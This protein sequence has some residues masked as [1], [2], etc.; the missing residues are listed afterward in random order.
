M[1]T[2]LLYRCRPHS[3]A[4]FRAAALQ[5]YADAEALF[6]Q[7]HRTGSVYLFGYAAEMIVKAAWFA[8]FGFHADQTITKAD[9]LTAVKLAPAM[10]V[11]PPLSNAHDIRG[12]GQS[13]FQL[14][15][16]LPGAEYLDASIG[17]GLLTH[18]AQV[19]AVWR[20]TLRYHKNTAYPHEVRGIRTAVEW[21]VTHSSIL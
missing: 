10:G 5:R 14:R 16:S 4:E 21:L 12:W 8:A 7:V 19:Y 18:S 17:T 11:T 3:V 1:P 2:P 20:E 6:R 9:I 15:A 13:L